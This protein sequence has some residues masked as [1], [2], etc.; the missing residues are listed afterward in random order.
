MTIDLEAY[1]DGTSPLE[2]G[3]AVPAPAAPIFPKR[4]ACGVV[5]QDRAA[6]EAQP[7]KG[8]WGDEVETLEFRN[9]VCG[10]T[11]CIATPRSTAE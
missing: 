2:G 1:M 6:W 3:P 5:Y 4:C 11:I 9:C 7:L 8:F 10:S